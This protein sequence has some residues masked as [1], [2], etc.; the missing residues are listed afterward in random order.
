MKM[1]EIIRATNAKSAHLFEGKKRGP[2]SKLNN[3]DKVL[4]MLMYYREYRTFT[5]IGSSYNISESQCWRIVTDVESRLIK[6]NAFKLPGKKKLLSSAREWEVVV[7][8][9]SEHSIERPQKNSVDT[10]LV[11]KRDTV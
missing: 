3:Y 9:V 2:K 10:T 11:R 4:M 6:S 8:D 1:V 5:H 7:V